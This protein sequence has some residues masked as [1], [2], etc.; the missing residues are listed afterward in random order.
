MKHNV[1]WS[2][3]FLFR[4]QTSICEQCRRK[5]ACVCVFPHAAWA[6]RPSQQTS[7]RKTVNSP[8][9]SPNPLYARAR[10]NR[11]RG[12]RGRLQPVDLRARNLLRAPICRR[13]LGRRRR[14]RRRRRTLLSLPFY[15]CCGSPLPLRSHITK[16]KIAS[17]RSSASVE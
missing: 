3:D 9:N 2:S 15:F 8:P 11:D 13:V 4:C 16:A 17:G 7:S 10:V 12:G 6:G 5:S 1:P 14:R